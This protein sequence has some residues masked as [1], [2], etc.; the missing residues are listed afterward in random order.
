MQ[1]FIEQIDEIAFVQNSANSSK[2]IVSVFAILKNDQRYSYI[3]KA[4]TVKIKKN[5]SEIW[6][7]G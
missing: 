6:V 3:H 5:K 7:E 1:E 4:I 2:T